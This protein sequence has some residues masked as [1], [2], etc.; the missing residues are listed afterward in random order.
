MQGKFNLVYRFFGCCFFSATSLV[1]TSQV[2]AEESLRINL[3]QELNQG[4]FLI[5]LKQHLGANTDS[6]TGKKN[7]TFT[8]KNDFLKLH[9]FNGLK[10]KSKKIN[11]TFKKIP[12]KKPYKVKRL[13]FGPFASYESAKKQA[14]S[15]KDKGYSALVA[16]PKTW[17]VWSP[18]EKNLPNKNL[19]YKVFQKF[20]KSHIVP[21]LVSEYSQQQLQGPIY[22]SS[23]AEIKINEINF[24]KNF[25]LVKDLYGTWTLIQKIKFDNYL[26]GVLPYEIGPNSPIEALKAQAVIARTW[27]IYN[28]ERF[29]MDKYHLCIT[30]QC[31]VYKPSQEKYK[32]VQKAI[33]DTS[34]LII[35]YMSKPINSFY[36]GSNGGIS[37][38][39][40]E[41]WMI[42][43]YPYFNPMIDGLDSLKKS[44][45]LPIK[46]GIELNKFLDSADER[47]YGNQH[48]L[49]RWEKILSSE[50]I[51][52]FLL[53]NNLIRDESELVDLNIINRGI[54][55]RVIKLE[56]NLKNS[57]K[58]L[59]LVKDDIRR[60]F[61]FL[62]SNLFTIN[63][64]NDNL[65]LF[66]GGGFG[67][68]VGLSQSGAIE[69]A[70]L[71]FSYEQILNHYYQDAKLE[72]IEILSQ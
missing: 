46:N 18:L 43:D 65:W 9:S 57:K 13:V 52:N 7:I 16:Y 47:I 58:P 14:Q 71:G 50:K 49:F 56:V 17:E 31:Q 45:K 39:A 41:S 30:T 32:N 66:K 2:V 33:Q 68:G 11:I 3:T 29:N 63:K 64:L 72:K 20:Y 28:S 25:F 48:S 15:L 53:K 36:H 22:I 1:F 62:P 70:K 12:L 59:I 19:N 23:D 6:L 27:A 61:S 24:G 37:A 44:F 40:S 51:Q 38:S 55:G 67:H 34:N 8:T 21:F 42:E 35:T 69:M 26:K 4:N 10:Y 60:I 5:G 54:S